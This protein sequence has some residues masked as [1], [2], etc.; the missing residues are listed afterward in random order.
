MA[1]ISRSSVRVI[2]LFGLCMGLIGA[3]GEFQCARGVVAFLQS[4]IAA[5]ASATAD[6]QEQIDQLTGALCGLSVQTGNP[7]PAE[8]C[9]LVVTVACESSKDV[10]SCECDPGALFVLESC[11]TDY[12]LPCVAE[13][14]G[15]PCRPLEGCRATFTR[16]AAGDDTSV[17][18]LANCSGGCPDCG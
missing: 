6:Q 11:E 1:R 14:G 16:I 4:E 7:A 5:L 13:P 15:P 2:V 17:E 12:S 10:S 3:G 8:L 9:E 18:V